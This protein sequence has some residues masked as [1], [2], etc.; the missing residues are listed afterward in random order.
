MRRWVLA[1]ALAAAAAGCTPVVESEAYYCGPEERCPP[2]QVCRETDNICVLPGD[3]QQ[4]AC[5]DDDQ[6]GAPGCQQATLVAKG[7][8]DGADAHHT[9]PLTTHDTC[10]VHL[11]ATLTYP[12]AFMPVA[13]SLL[14]PTGAVVATSA[15][16]SSAGGAETACL[17]VDAAPGTAYQLDV[18]AAS[19]APTCD[20]AC[21]FNRYLV[22]VSILSP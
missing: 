12:V 2:D 13:I 1:A 22:S 19:G 17:E 8:V 20:G 10:P 18:A 14:D 21:A 16:C 3:F 6:L 4:F 15:P 11:S 5:T 9:Y 7:C